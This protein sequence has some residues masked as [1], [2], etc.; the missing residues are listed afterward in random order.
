MLRIVAGIWKP[1]TSTK[2]YVYASVLVSLQTH[3]ISRNQAIRYHTMAGTLHFVT[4]YKHSVR[5]ILG[6]I[7]IPFSAL[8]LIC[9]NVFTYKIQ[10]YS[11]GTICVMCSS[12][13]NIC[14]I[15]DNTSKADLI[16][17]F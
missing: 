17:L 14:F 8:F 15:V 9:L 7:D 11:T 6:Y 3:S 10:S 1:H 12:K 16:I 13:R 4:Q 5:R 2:K